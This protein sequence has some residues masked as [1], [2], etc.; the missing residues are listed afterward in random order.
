MKR[1]TSSLTLVA[2]LFIAGGVAEAHGGWHGGV[3]FYIGGPVWWGGA[4][5]AY[6]YPGYYPYP[7]YYAYPGYYPYPRYYPYPVYAPPAPVYIQRPPTV[8]RYSPRSPPAPRLE[9]YTLSAQELFAFDSDELRTPQPKLDEIASVLSS[10]PQINKVRIAGHTDRIG[11]D[12]Y[13]LELSQRR[14]DAVKAYLVGRGV[15]ADRLIAVGKGKANPVVRCENSDR[16]ALIKC[17][18]LN[19]RVEVEQITVTRRVG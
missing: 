15:A 11:S 3:G 16:A 14:A 19:R 6:S 9:R 5:Y 2:I 18:E 7:G 13:N 1:L 4:P 10:N 8:V 12:E 17:L